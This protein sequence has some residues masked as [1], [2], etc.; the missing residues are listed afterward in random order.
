MLPAMHHSGATGGN[1]M[2]KLV[3]GL[4][5]AVGLATPAL[6][7]NCPN[8]MKQFEEAL[9]TTTVD[10]ATKASAQALYDTGKAAHEAGD[11]DASVAALTEALALLGVS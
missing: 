6:A 4:V 8:L 10:D 5:L 9:L 3:L 7:H 2:K 1:I 11:H